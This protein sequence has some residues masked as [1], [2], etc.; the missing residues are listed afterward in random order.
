MSLSTITPAG[1]ARGAFPSLATLAA[2]TAL[3]FALAGVAVAGYLAVQNLQGETGVCTIAHGCATV[4]KSR[5]GELL[6][7]PVSVPGLALYL[8]LTAAAA[9]RLA[10]PRGAGAIVT[11][12]AF[13]GAVGGLAFSAY[14]TAV[15]AFVLDA[16]C[17]Y[18]IAS[19]ILI[20]GLFAAWLAL[21][22]LDRRSTS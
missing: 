22:V 17:I 20:S 19:A 3:V 18:C 13:L 11:P 21:V 2:A 7:V 9:L 8:G 5:Y 4:Q 15:E 6:G 16:W 1:R 12:L 10:A 14:L